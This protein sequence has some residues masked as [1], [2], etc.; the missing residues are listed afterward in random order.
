[1]GLT[2]YY[3]MFTLKTKVSLHR[4]LRYIVVRYIKCGRFNDS[5]VRWTR[6]EGNRTT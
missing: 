4:G 1:M 5:T 6:D 2:K 3:V